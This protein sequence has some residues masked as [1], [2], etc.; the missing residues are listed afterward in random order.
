MESERL[1][2]FVAFACEF[3]LRSPMNTHQSPTSSAVGWRWAAMGGSD[4]NSNNNNTNQNMI[5]R[6]NG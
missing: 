2:T 6:I 3:G 5:Y 1:N 4:N